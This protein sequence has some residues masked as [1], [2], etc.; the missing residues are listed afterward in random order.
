[1]PNMAVY[2]GSSCGTAKEAMQVAFDRI[3]DDFNFT[4]YNLEFELIGIAKQPCLRFALGQLY[5]SASI[6]KETHQGG[7]IFA[8][9][10]I[11]R[12]REDH[13]MPAELDSYEMP[14]G[15][16][17]LRDTQAF[18]RNTSRELSCRNEVILPRVAI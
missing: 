18:A 8:V 7:N 12:E 4:R 3:I 2:I 14:L 6:T 15:T 11:I 5:F 10:I 1:V 13:V 16:G 9:K 17:F